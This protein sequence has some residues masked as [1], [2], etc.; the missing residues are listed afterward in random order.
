[1]MRWLTAFAGAWMIC[2]AGFFVIWLLGLCVHC[3][4][5]SGCVSQI[6][7]RVLLGAVDYK[8]VLVRGTLAA[9]AIIGIAWLKRQSR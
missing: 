5:T 8:S 6:D 2:V 1:M 3:M 7:L 4:S 9:I